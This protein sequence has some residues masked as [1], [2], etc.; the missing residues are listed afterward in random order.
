LRS[1]WIVIEQSHPYQ[2]E[3]MGKIRGWSGLRSAVI[4]L[5]LVA[6]TA[7]GAEAA[8]LT[9]QTSTSMDSGGISGAN[10][11]SFLPVSSATVDLS[12]GAAN[13]ALGKFVIAPLPDKQTTVYDHT[14]FTMTF[15]PQTMDS[16]PANT[17]T[18][19]TFTGFLTGKV[20]G[21]NISTVT[22]TFDQA[23]T[24]SYP[25]SDQTLSFKL[26]DSALSLVASGSGGVTTA[27]TQVMSGPGIPESPV[28]EPGTIALF[29]TTA[30]GLGLRRYVQKR[31]RQPRI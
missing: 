19:L 18:P 12:G 20:T 27:Q 29:L 31:R 28:P 3:M 2:E 1:E 7:T 17:S 24:S 16:K 22:A 8:V 4:A 30:G 21:P 6:G 14:K 25:I 26:P 9:Y 23:P 11:I 13:A 5:G 10:V 15:L